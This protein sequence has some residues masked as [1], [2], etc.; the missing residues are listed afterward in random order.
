MCIELITNCPRSFHNTC[1][2]EASL[3]DFHELVVTILR[4]S[5]ESLP[6]KIIKYRNCKNFDEDKFRCLISVDIFQMTSLNA[7]NKFVPLKKKCLRANHCRIANKELKAKNLI[8]QSC[9]DQSFVT[10][11]LNIKLEQLR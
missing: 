4:T 9:K 6:P 1:L 2:Y 5:F 7:L 3:P 8:R 11:T 10:H